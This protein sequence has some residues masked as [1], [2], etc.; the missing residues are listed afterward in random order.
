LLT[1][2]RAKNHRIVSARSGDPVLLRGVNLSGLEYS[3]APGGTFLDAARIDEGVVREIV[4]GWRA[5]VVR[6]PFN[7]DWVLRGT[8]SSTAA[9]YLQALDRLIAWCEAEGAY[10]LLDLQ[11]LDVRR[12]FGLRRD[13][14]PNRVPPLPDGET[15]S[16]WRVLADRY[17]DAPCVL[18]DLFNEPH[19]PIRHATDP[20]RDDLNPLLGV[21]EDGSTY[22]LGAAKVTMAVWQAW[23]REL[24]RTIRVVHP[25][26]LIFVSGVRWA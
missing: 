6:V 11:W 3:A 20:A 18:F 24:V 2:L 22:V 4:R 12:V 5:N 13:G 21:R 16:L 8:A 1:P 23:A 17:R 7:Q 14:T 19:D 10:T 15:V 25:A 9:E 26:S